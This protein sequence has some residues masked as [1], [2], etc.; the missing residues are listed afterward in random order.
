MPATK[1]SSLDPSPCLQSLTSLPLLPANVF[2]LLPGFLL[3]E[4]LFAFDSQDVRVE[5][6]D[7]RPL[8]RNCSLSFVGY[9]CKAFRCFFYAETRARV[10]LVL[11][12]ETRHE[13]RLGQ[14]MLLNVFVLQTHQVFTCNKLKTSIDWMIYF[15]SNHS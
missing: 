2:G 12:V 15:L 13:A 7:A 10:H 5:E 11:I 1:P 3:I 14:E 9:S 4:S 6:C 8:G